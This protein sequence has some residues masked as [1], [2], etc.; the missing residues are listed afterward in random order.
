MNLFAELKIN[1]SVYLVVG[2]HISVELSS[3]VIRIRLKC[4]FL[5]I[6]SQILRNWR[7]G[8]CV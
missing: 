2:C 6:V 3:S 8:S 5:D 1:L 4:R 7:Y